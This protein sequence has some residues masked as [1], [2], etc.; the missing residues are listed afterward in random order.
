MPLRFW[1]RS[2]IA[3]ILLAELGAIAVVASLL[4]ALMIWL[5]QQ[6]MKRYQIQTLTEQARL[7]GDVTMTPAGTASVRLPSN[8]TQ[9]YATAYDGR[10]YVV[11]DASGRSLTQSAFASLVPW[12]HVAREPRLRF[13]RIGTIVGVSQPIVRLGVPLWVIVTQDEAGPGA[14]IDDVARAF[15]TRYAPI[16]LLILLLLP[17]V[18]S[19]LIRRLVLEVRSASLQAAA[20]CSETLDI[21]LSERGLP[22]EILPLVRAVNDLL[23]RLQQSF[24]QQA[25]FIANVAHELRTPLAT[26]KFQLE[27]VDQGEVRERLAGTVT[28]L[29]HVVSQLQALA[30]LESTSLSLSDF[31]LVTLSREV[32]GELAPDILAQGDTIA[33]QAPDVPLR[34]CA[35]RTLIALALSNIISNATR[36]TPPG[37]AVSVRITNGPMIQVTDNG[38]GIAST[39]PAHAQL[40]YWRADNR[41]SDSAGLGLSIVARIM[42]V[43]RGA[44]AIENLHGAGARVTLRFPIK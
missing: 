23:V 1:P 43:H 22:L 6:Q 19:L 2:L 32:I 42:E 24:Q 29:S 38:P 33:L 5:L 44:V 41:R 4:P 21:R 15:T 40:R 27:A 20:I 3:R 39:D 14:I 25:E 11:T 10:A 30:A 8:L 37:T 7:I 13:F 36:H 31:D 17:L 28:R 35:N 12:Q 34:V 16:L 18:N 26:L 9:V